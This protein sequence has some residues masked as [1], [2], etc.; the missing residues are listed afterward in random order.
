[1]SKE[2]INIHWF[3]RDLRLKDNTSLFHSLKERKTLCIFIF[4]KTILNKLPKDDARVTFIYDLLKSIKHKL[5]EL[6]SDLI[7]FYDTPKDAYEELIKKYA[8]QKVYTNEDY[9]P[10]AIKRDLQIKKLL[11]KNN[12]SF[13]MF[14]DQVIFAKN[15]ILKK[16]GKPYT[17]YTPYKNK[18]LEKFEDTNIKELD[19]KK[20]FKNLLSCN[21]SR[22]ITLE[23]M[24]FTRNELVKIKT[25]I[26]KSIIENYHETRDYP[27][28]DGTSKL[29]HHLRFGTISPRRCAFIAKHLNDTWLSEIIWREFFMQILYHFPHVTKDSFKAKYDKIQWLNDKSLYNKWCQGQTG[30][31]LVDAGMR[32]L[33]ATGFMHNRVRMLCASFLIK[34]LLIDWRWG[35]KYFA[36]K[37]MDYDLSAN[38][39][40]W[41]WAAGCG[42]DAAPYFRI[43][44]PELQFKKFDKAA[45]YVKKWVPEFGT[46]KYTS[47][48]IE[49]KFA[50]QRALITYKE[51]LNNE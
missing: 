23:Q 8:I 14:K 51:A 10:Y 44:N 24:G 2:K 46:D 25:T 50:Y 43:F 49:H 11:D 12:I 6:G 33:N 39:G 47:A 48:I 26:K 9:E 36:K 3:R 30:Y 38:N 22:M 41:Q 37:L 19:P 1:M 13:E 45:Q 35:E 21:K 16:D 32:E 31:P 5:N 42:C 40:N 28:I 29:G 4:D 15:D 18:W 17:V 7:T 34:H 27:A 20:Y